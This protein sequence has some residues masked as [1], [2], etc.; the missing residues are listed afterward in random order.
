MVI[1][2]VCLVPER[3]LLSSVAVLYHANG[4]AAK[5]RYIAKEEVQPG[6][7]GFFLKM[8]GKALG[9]ILFEV[10]RVTWLFMCRIALWD[11]GAGGRIL[12]FSLK[13]LKSQNRS[14]TFPEQTQ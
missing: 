1:S 4:W 9:T 13:P 6:S 11:W 12:N 5:S 7:Q 10:A 2:L 8:G 14:V 3:I